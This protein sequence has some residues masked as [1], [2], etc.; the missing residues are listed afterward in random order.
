MTALL[1][2]ADDRSGALETAAACAGVGWSAVV[3]P[4]HGTAAADCTVVDLAS[5]HVDPL[6][7]GRRVAE[8]AGRVNGRHAHKID[9]TLRGPWAWELAARH[10]A[11]GRAVLLVPAFPAAGRTCRGGVVRVD[12]RPVDSV[13]DPRRPVASARP[14][15][16]LRRAGIDAVELRPHD[17]AGWLAGRPG[18]AVCDA[19]SDADLALAA[20]GWAAGGSCDLA[21]TAATVAAG[22]RALRPGPPAAAPALP[23]PVLVVCGSLHPVARAQ[24]A[25]LVE[26]GAVVATTGAEAATALAAGRDAVLA[27]PHVAG[28]VD[29]AAAVQAAGALA[30]AA[31]AAAPAAGTVVIVGGDTAAALLG[32]TAVAV[33]G[34]LAPGVAW[35]PSQHGLPL[36]VAKPGGIGGADL[37]VRLRS[38][39]MPT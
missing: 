20:S 38:A 31:R 13:D 19:D 1:V 27:T 3:V 4:R 32:D 26:A 39:R 7:A 16:H 14:A 12:G 25:A 11:T 6:E 15:E 21:G 34:L 10:R 36:L 22:A 9:S 24:V 2:A 28:P 33:G 35:C 37:L 29:D 8:V 18:V 5:R 23:G 17:V 30:G